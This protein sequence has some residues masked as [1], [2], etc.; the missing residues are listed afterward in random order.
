[1]LS[2]V[3]LKKKACFTL[4]HKTC[5][6]KHLLLNE[7]LHKNLIFPFLPLDMMVHLFNI[8]Q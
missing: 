6:M 7:V 1:M 2:H 4:H 3:F 5:M 8:A